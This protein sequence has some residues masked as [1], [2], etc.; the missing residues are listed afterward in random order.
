MIH[1]ECVVPSREE[2]LINWSLTRDTKAFL[3]TSFWQRHSQEFTSY[4]TLSRVA[5]QSRPDCCRLIAGDHCEIKRVTQVERW[6]RKN[7]DFQLKLGSCK[8][9]KQELFGNYYTSDKELKFPLAFAIVCH[10][11]SQQIFRLLK[12]IYRP[13][14]IY[15]VHYD[16]KAGKA[17]QRLFLQVSECIGN[18][19]IASKIEDVVWGHPSLLNAQLNCMSDLLQYRSKVQWRY[20]I[21]LNG[22]ELPLRTNYELVTML[23]TQ[24]GYSVIKSYPLLEKLDIERFTYRVTRINRP[25]PFVM[26]SN[27]RLGPVPFELTVYKSRCFNALSTEF[28]QFLVQNETARVFHRYLQDVYS[29]EEY[30]YATMYNMRG[31][32]GAKPCDG[33]SPPFEVSLMRWLKEVRGTWYDYC[34]GTLHHSMCIFGAG[35]LHSIFELYLEARLPDQSPQTASFWYGLPEEIETVAL[36]VFLNKYS[37]KEDHIVM[38]CMEERLVRQN[39]LEY[40]YDRVG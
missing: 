17:F 24:K 26:L 38:D 11:D 15:C 4:K 25:H 14:N 1:R 36:P 9:I 22:M 35:D 10:R 8:E 21:N 34:N 23:E 32:P 31:A 16:R 12:T 20:V 2:C 13:H 19:V 37:A 18:I 28:V 27:Q 29:A 7:K 33:Y 30:Y 40:Y 3:N 39:M 5:D 6:P